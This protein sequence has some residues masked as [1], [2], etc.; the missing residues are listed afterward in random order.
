MNGSAVEPGEPENLHRRRFLSRACGILA[1]SLAVVIGSPLVASLVGTI[2][3][4]PK[5]LFSKTPGFPTA[6]EGQPIK[7]R[8][9]YVKTD[10]YM[11]TQT[12]EEVWVVKHSASKATVFSPICPHLG[13]RTD[14]HPESEHF[15][16]PCHGSVFSITGKV[17]GGPSP[18]SMDSL[19]HKI[20][21]GALSVEW[22]E[23]ETGIPE[24]VRI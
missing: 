22:E 6:P 23:F 18:R 3:R 5:M 10:A 13:C 4:K 15:I 16:C 8:L 2:N 14:W 11:Q 24:K 7:L 19:S 1:A 12:S 9:N 20:E 21:D 17:L